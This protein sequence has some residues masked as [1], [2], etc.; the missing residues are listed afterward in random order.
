MHNQ[1]A[2]YTYCTINENMVQL[3]MAKLLT[4]R[5]LDVLSYIKQYISKNNISPSIVEIKDAFGVSSTRGI[6]KHLISL[7][8]KG[9]ILRSSE[10]RGIRILDNGPKEN[11]TLIPILGYANAGQPLVNAVEE[12]LGSLEVDVK[13]IPRNSDLFAL[14]IKGDSMNRRII[15]GV[16]MQ[17][18]YFAIIQKTFNLPNEGE[19][20]LA[21]IDDSATLKNF[22]KGDNKFI[23]KPKSSNPIHKPIYVSSGSQAYING[24]VIAV[25]ENH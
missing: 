8:K 22:H 24:R 20:V 6:V 15:N 1:S 16:K 17:N 4:R 9:F 18:G 14:I 19:P 12:N 10:N 2:T 3:I 25:L 21:I 11:F 13:L 7:E 23:L 5:Q